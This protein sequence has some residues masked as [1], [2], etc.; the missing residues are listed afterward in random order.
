MIYAHL[1]YVNI[2]APLTSYKKLQVQ[3]YKYKNTIQGTG[4]QVQ[5]TGDL[6]QLRGIQVQGTG[7]LRQ[8][9][10]QFLREFLQ[11]LRG[12]GD[13]FKQF[14]RGTGDNQQKTGKEGKNY[15]FP[16]PVSG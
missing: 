1:N 12:T 11:F 3:E 16:S 9:R 14:L 2:K 5:G 7:D 6:R 10:V 15:C 13:N 4:I 8:L